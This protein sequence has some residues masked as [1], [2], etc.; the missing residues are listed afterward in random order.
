MNNEQKKKIESYIGIALA[1]L[2]ILVF[3]ATPSHMNSHFDYTLNGFIDKYLLG[4]GY[5]IPSNYP[6][7]AKTVNSFSVVLAIILGVFVGIWR[8]DGI[9][10]EKISK[11]ALIGFFIILCLGV[12]AFFT[13]LNPQE[14]SEPTLRRSFGTGESFHNNPVLF[15]AMM[16]GKTICI[17]LGI[18][19]PLAYLLYSLDKIRK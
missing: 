14:F 3:I 9:N 17:Y 2:P 19:V 1:I 5:Y 4:K 8:K 6:F 16:V 15:L 18:R 10:S 7:A 12:A 13:G 11:N